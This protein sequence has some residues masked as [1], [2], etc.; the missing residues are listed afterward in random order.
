MG[1][2]D[3]KL[4]YGCNK[5]DLGTALRSYQKDNGFHLEKRQVWSRDQSQLPVQK[6][7][8]N[9]CLELLHRRDIAEIFCKFCNSIL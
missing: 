1:L 4:C 8:L 7:L 3:C 5:F 6:W 9:F 2:R